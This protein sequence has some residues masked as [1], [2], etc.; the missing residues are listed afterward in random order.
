M[1]KIGCK[2]INN[3]CECPFVTTERTV[4]AGC[5]SD[6]HCSADHNHKIA[7]YVEYASEMPDNIP[8]WC[9]LAK[10]LSQGVTSRSSKPS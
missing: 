2:K 4:G 7:G 6:Y 9:P 1:I 3:C 5:A 8:E 10:A